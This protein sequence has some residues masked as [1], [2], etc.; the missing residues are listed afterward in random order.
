MNRKNFPALTPKQT[1]QLLTK[2][3]TL[4]KAHELALMNMGSKE[5]GGWTWMQCCE[6]ATIQME[7]VGLQKVSSE[8][9]R[10]SNVAFRKNECFLHPQALWKPREPQLFAVFPE[11]KVELHKFCTD[12]KTL[13]TLC[14]EA[15]RDHLV[16]NLIPNLHEALKASRKPN[17]ANS[18]K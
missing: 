13:Q 11:I 8:T 16:D 17:S 6:S 15:V 12:P 5:P 9:V 3:M 14:V 10:R 2:C 1:V 4:M 18:T 7:N